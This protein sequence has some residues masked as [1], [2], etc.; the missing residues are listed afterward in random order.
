VGAYGGAEPDA[1]RGLG[2]RHPGE[3]LDEVNGPAVA[4]ARGEPL[5]AEL[6]TGPVRDLGGGGRP[7]RVDQP[8]ELLDLHQDRAHALIVDAGE[9]DGR[10][11]R[12]Q[13]L[14]LCNQ[15]SDLVHVF[16]VAGATDILIHPIK[17]GFSCG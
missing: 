16:T 5:G 15:V 9:R 10:S 13:R 6:V 1:P 8:A 2:L 11:L 17:P 3:M 12:E 14:G 7:E 4:E